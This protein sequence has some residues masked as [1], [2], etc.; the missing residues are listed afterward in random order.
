MEWPEGTL[1]WRLPF[2]LGHETAGTVAALGSG[3]TGVAE[4]DHVL[5]YGPWGCGACTQC[6]RGAENLCL[7]RF[8][9][10]GA[11]CGLGYDGGLAEYVVVPSPRLLVPLGDLDPV[12]SAPLTDAA[13]TPYHALKPE[14]PRLVPGS[15]ALVL[16]VGGLGSIAVQLLRALSPARVVAADL[17]ERPRALALRFGAHAALDAHGLTPADVREELGGGAALVLDFVGNDQTLALAAGAL[18]IGGHVALV[19]L[20]GGSFPMTFGAT[21]LEWSLRRPSW[22]TLPELH[23]VVALARAGEIEIAV[24][25]LRLDEAPDGYRRLRDGDVQGRAVVVP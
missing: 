20:G 18:E 17:R 2:T 5:V 3:A 23:E 11:G 8:Q 1:P 24:E 10:P 12:A 9:R 21:P 22:G 6:V 14:L 25:R 13:L 7:H 4:G 16:G 19:G 15:S